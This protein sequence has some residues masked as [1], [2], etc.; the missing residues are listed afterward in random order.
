MA[1]IWTDITLDDLE[2]I[3]FADSDPETDEIEEEAWSDI[4]DDYEGVTA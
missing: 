2:E 1:N 4:L 3:L